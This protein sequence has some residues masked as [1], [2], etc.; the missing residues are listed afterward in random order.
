MLCIISRI[1]FKSAI[2]QLMITFNDGL[3]ETISK[4]SSLLQSG[5]IFDLKTPYL[6]E[7]SDV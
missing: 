1:G 7:R 4:D 3:F 5:R 6:P 2:Y